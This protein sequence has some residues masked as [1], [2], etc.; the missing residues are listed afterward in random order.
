MEKGISGGRGTFQGKSL[1]RW[2]LT[3]FVYEI[4]FYFSYFLFASLILHVEMFWVNYPTAFFS[5][6]GLPGK[7]VHGRGDFRS[8]WEND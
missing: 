1:H 8:D 4:I 7:N 6:F 2:D 5:V 3:E